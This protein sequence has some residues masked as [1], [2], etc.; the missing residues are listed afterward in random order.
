MDLLTLGMQNKEPKKFL[1]EYL[2][3]KFN[4]VTSE[5]AFPHLKNDDEI[6]DEYHDD[7][8]LKEIIEGRVSP[9]CKEHIY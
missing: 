9:W 4:N 7:N 5:S 1:D 6:V 8:P 2:V 3:E